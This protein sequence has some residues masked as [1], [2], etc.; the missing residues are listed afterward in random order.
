MAIT[1]GTSSIQDA[2]LSYTPETANPNRDIESGTSTFSRIEPNSDP[3]ITPRLPEEQ[4]NCM[5]SPVKKGAVIGGIL[6]GGVGCLAGPVAGV[7]LGIGGAL[8]GAAIGA[9]V[10]FVSNR[11]GSS[12]TPQ[13]MNGPVRPDRAGQLPQEQSAN[14]QRSAP[15]ATGTHS[16]PSINVIMSTAF[17]L[18]F[19]ADVMDW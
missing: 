11:C 1:A 5:S 7:V 10:K 13:V 18:G 15:A 2:H 8:V 19:A 12:Q 16:G 14:T 6:A 4:Q 3:S 17:S 9:L